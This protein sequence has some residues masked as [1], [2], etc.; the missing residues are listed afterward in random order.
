M[1]QF[2]TDDIT[3]LVSPADNHHFGSFANV[4]AAA[5]SVPPRLLAYNRDDVLSL[6]FLVDAAEHL[7]R[8]PEEIS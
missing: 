7:W 1:R 5:A 4:D 6:K 3:R 8:E 2:Q